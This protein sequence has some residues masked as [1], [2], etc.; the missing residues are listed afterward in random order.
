[1]KYLVI[2]PDGIGDY[3]SDALGDKTPLEVARIPNLTHFARIGKVGSVRLVPDRMETASHV[4][5][6]SLMG[7]EPKQFVTGPGPL[8]AANLEVKL[9]ENVQLSSCRLGV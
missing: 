5:F 1:M 9:E 6:V 3:P 2:I 4:A 8:E 7:Y